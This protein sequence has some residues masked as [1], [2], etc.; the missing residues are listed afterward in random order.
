LATGLIMHRFSSD[1]I[2]LKA[3]YISYSSQNRIRAL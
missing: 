3:V 1:F 2:L